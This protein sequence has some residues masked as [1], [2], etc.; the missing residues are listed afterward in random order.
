MIPELWRRADRRMAKLRGRMAKL[1]G[2]WPRFALRLAGSAAL[3]ST[4]QAYRS[5]KRVPGLQPTT[6]LD[7]AR[8]C[9]VR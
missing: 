7:G 1:R 5:P 2:L 3:T 6:G 9:G 4:F 8:C